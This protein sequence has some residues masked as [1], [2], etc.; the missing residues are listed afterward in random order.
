MIVELTDETEIDAGIVNNISSEPTKTYSVVF[1]D[2]DGTVLKTQN[3]ESGK[4]ATAPANPSREGY[5]F[6]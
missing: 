3:V 4:S 6:S 1:K 2:Y 5:A